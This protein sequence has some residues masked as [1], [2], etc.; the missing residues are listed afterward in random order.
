MPSAYIDCGEHAPIRYYMCRVEAPE[1]QLEAA[2]RVVA[3]FLVSGEK[4]GVLLKKILEPFGARAYFA[5][6]LYYISVPPSRIT[7]ITDL[8]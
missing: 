3:Q 6:S 4:D 1:D 2:K 5:S 8:I 7:S